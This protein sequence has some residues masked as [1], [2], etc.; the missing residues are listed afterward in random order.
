[1]NVR[2]AGAYDLIEATI[3]S[4]QC[5]LLDGGVATELPQQHGQ[6]Y[7]KLWG[8]EALA[9]TPEDVL[10]VHRR[11]VDAGVNVGI[12]HEA[13]HRKADQHAYTECGHGDQ[14][15]CSTL[16]L[17]PRLD[18]REYLPRHEEEIVANA[19]QGNSDQQ[20][21]HESTG[22]AKGEQDVAQ[23]PRGPIL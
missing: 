7:E 20:H 3:R 1:M 23:R 2:Y 14:T 9:S 19:V 10:A 16:V 18:I 8:I 11:Y 15:L 6:D 13:G 21:P 5:V 17:S 22:V 12:R 4:Q